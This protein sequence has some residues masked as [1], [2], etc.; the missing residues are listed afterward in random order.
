MSQSYLCEIVW[1]FEQSSAM[2]NGLIRLR[3]NLDPIIGKQRRRERKSATPP[4]LFSPQKH[5][6]GRALSEGDED[7]KRG[8][9]INEIL[10]AFSPSHSEIS[11]QISYY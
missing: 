2:A 6:V 11:R 10:I 9:S 4:R 8:P 5:K 7:G 3:D 1:A